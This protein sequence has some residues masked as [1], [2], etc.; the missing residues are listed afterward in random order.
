MPSVTTLPSYEQI[1]V[2]DQI[3]FTPDVANGR[4]WTVRTRDERYIVATAPAPF[5]PSGTLI[6]TVVDLTGWADMEYNGQGHG[7]VRSSL[8]TLGG[9]SLSGLDDEGCDAI[10][11]AL[12]SGEREL[13]HRRVCSVEAITVVKRHG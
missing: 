5:Q 11:T 3:R 1:T 13:S 2:G 9:G 8:N 6:Y 4:K 10:L 12:T 7:I